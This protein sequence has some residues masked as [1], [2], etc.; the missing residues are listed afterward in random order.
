MSCL[1]TVWIEGQ[2]TQIQ[3]AISQGLIGIFAC[4][5]LHYDPGNNAFKA[6]MKKPE[7]ESLL[8]DISAW[9]FTVKN[10][11]SFLERQT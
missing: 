2:T 7:Y 8:V 6:V 1:K 4:S 10:N 3:I 9:Y 11:A 5:F